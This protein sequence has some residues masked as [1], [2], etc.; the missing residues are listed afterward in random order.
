VLH[1][2]I[3]TLGILAVLFAPV[4]V[5][6]THGPS[7]HGLSVPTS[8]SIQ[9]HGHGHDHA[10]APAKADAVQGAS[11]IHDAT[12]HE[13]QLVAMLAGGDALYLAAFSGSSPSCSQ[14]AAGNQAEGPR[15]PPRG[16]TV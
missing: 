13:H 11:P 7:T 9:D 1:R 5:A 15:R 4:G 6:L 12:D 14:S 8:L 10:A 2:L 3:V 16:V